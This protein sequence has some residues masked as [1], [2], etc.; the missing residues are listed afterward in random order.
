MEVRERFN[1][2]IVFITHDPRVAGQCAIVSPWMQRG[3]IVEQGKQPNS[4]NPG[5]ILLLLCRSMP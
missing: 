4:V 3:E 1:L 2:A 5:S